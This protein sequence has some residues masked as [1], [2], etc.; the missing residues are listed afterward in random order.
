MDVV[1]MVLAMQV[2]VSKNLDPSLIHKILPQSPDQ[3]LEIVMD[4]AL[5]LIMLLTLLLIITFS[6]SAE[7]I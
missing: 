5:I 6:I 7:G 2:S 3:L 1:N 4:T